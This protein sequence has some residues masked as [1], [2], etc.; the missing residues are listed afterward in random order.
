MTGKAVAVVQSSQ[1]VLPTLIE[2]GGQRLR[3]RVVEFFGATIRNDNTR[4]AYMK[5]C[6]AFFDFLDT[7]AERDE[8]DDLKPVR[9]VA[10]I[11]AVHV[12]AWLEALQADELSVPT[13]KQY[14]AAVR[15]LLDHL[16][17]GGF[18]PFNPALSVKAPRQQT[19]KGKTPTLSADEAGELLRST[20]ATAFSTPAPTTSNSA[21][22]TAATP[23]R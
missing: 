9:G 13:Q 10:D 15:M 21:F 23:S 11:D 3:R 19:H 4:K 5:A 12:A 22:P 18:I 6:G 16:T 20:P 14:L 1:V 2:A 7:L 17:T 8:L